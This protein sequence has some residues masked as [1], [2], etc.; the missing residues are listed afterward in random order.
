MQLTNYEQQVLDGKEGYPAQ[1]SMQILVQLGEIYGAKRMIPVSKVH[2]PGSS[3][4]VA[5]QAGTKFVEKM[6]EQKLKER[7]KAA[8][9]ALKGL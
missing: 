7:V 1:K 8:I 3:I 6:V 5:G 2:M 4:V 9:K